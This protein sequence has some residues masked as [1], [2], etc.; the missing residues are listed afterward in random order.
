MVKVNIGRHL[1]LINFRFFAA[2]EESQP[3]QWLFYNI[4]K[5]YLFFLCS[6]LFP[7]SSSYHIS[8]AHSNV[9]IQRIDQTVSSANTTPSM[10]D[11]SSWILYLMYHW[12]VT[13]YVMSPVQNYRTDTLLQG[14]KA[15]CL[16]SQPLEW[17]WCYCPTFMPARL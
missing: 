3:C 2:I 12:L 11:S 7:V 9:S 5:R 8:F 16:S 6:H 13:F 10:W 14:A 1:C 17:L 4:D 15:R